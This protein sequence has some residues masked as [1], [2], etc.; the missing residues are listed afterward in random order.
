MANYLE[1]DFPI[2]KRGGS[3]A[4]NDKFT[5]V[6]ATFVDLVD[7]DIADDETLLENVL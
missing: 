3:S 7:A 5:L 2:G 1:D 6:T 4:P